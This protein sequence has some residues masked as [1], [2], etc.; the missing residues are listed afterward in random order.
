ME[1]IFNK[2]NKPDS[3]SVN[4]SQNEATINGVIKAVRTLAIGGA[5]MGT[6]MVFNQPSAS[7][8]ITQADRNESTKIETVGT[9]K[10]PAVNEAICIK[11]AEYRGLDPKKECYTTTGDTSP[12]VKVPS[13][14]VN[15]APRAPSVNNRER[16]TTPNQP[17][18]F[19]YRKNGNV[20][21][22]RAPSGASSQQEQLFIRRMQLANPGIQIKKVQ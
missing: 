21:E 9:I 17:S 10:N 22:Y 4:P 14:R 6:S 7:A 18:K 3:K 11:S 8:E 5:M 2:N 16:A 12:T 19:Q 20:L 13:S 1:N 15:S